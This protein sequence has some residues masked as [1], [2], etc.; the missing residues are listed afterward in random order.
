MSDREK[1]GLL[2]VLGRRVGDVGRDTVDH[3]SVPSPPSQPHT[4]LWRSCATARRE[5]HEEEEEEEEEE[6][7]EG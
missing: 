2:W 3:R 7:G 1:V 4:Q 5:E 6:K